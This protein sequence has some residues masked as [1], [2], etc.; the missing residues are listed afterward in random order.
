MSKKEWYSIRVGAR[1]KWKTWRTTHAVLE[2]VIYYG[3]V[4]RINSNGSQ[5]L[6]QF[7]GDEFERWFGRLGIDLESKNDETQTQ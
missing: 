6:I 5:A 3:K 1:V 7:D 2:D 4:I